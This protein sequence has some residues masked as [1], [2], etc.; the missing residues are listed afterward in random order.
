VR[1]WRPFLWLRVHP[2]VGDRILAAVCVIVSVPT[3]FL[4]VPY[5]QVGLTVREPDLPGLLLVLLTCIPL[6]WRR[7]YPLAVLIV[8]ALPTVVLAAL[9][10]AG[11][12][13][14]TLLI[15]AYTVAAYDTRR[16][17]VAA[18]G[19]SV[20]AA[21]LGVALSAQ[22]VGLASFVSNFALLTAAWAFGRSI[23]FRRAYTASLEERA[24]RLEAER[25]ADLRAVVADER[26]R[27]A[28]E[29]HDVVAHHVSVMTV[30]AA[31]AQRILARDVTR[32]QEAMAAVEATGR[33]AL[34]EMRRM[35]GVLRGDES[36]DRDVTSALAPQ[37]GI[38][39][40]PALVDELH[41]AGLHVEADLEDAPQPV[42]AGV[43]LT[44]Y[45][46]VQEALTNTLKHAGPTRARVVVRYTAGGLDLLVEDHGRGLATLLAQ[47]GTRQGQGLLGRRERISLYGGRLYAGPRGGGGY[48]VR[49]RI[50][51]DRVSA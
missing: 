20:L 32:A 18:F 41:R 12:Y 11:L 13:G 26:A 43:D 45:R 34:M 25:E 9:N 33:D 4:T 49:A 2:W 6:A 31:A 48:A 39:D 30:Q 19:I 21:M 28:R 29:L 50:P 47:D 37:P 8:I 44:V 10:Y 36:P 3:L 14:L 7:R 35:V 40:I 46:I 22:V 16:R 51:L 24:S 1:S 15:A 23:A 27:I 38:A 17:A 5:E 42:G